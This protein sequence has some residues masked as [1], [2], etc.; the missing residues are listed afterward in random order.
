MTTLQSLREQMNLL[1]RQGKVAHAAAIAEQFVSQN[2]SNVDGL[3]TAAMMASQLAAFDRSAEL[4]R[5]VVQLQPRHVANRAALGKALL[6]SGH[7]DEAEAAFDKALALERTNEH[8]ICGKA[9]VFNR[10]GRNED[11]IALL[12]PLIGTAAETPEVALQY[13]TVCHQ[14]GRREEAMTV[15]RRHLGNSVAAGQVRARL[16]FLLGRVAEESQLYEEAFKAYEEANRIRAAQTRFD[17]PLYEQ[18]AESIMAF[19]SKERLATLRRASCHSEAPVF[20]CGMPRSGTTLLDQIVHA[21]PEGLGAGEHPELDK[22]FVALFKARPNLPFPEF[23]VDLQRS[24]LDA[25][26]WGYLA[27]VMKPRPKAARVSDKYMR[28]PHLMGFAWMLFPH[29]RIIWSR[30][31]PMDTCFSCFTNPLPPT[32]HPY[33]SDLT[34]LAF[35]YRIHE[36]L[37]KHWQ[38]VLDLPFLEVE[39]EKLVA[40]PEPMIRALIEFLG[41]PWSDACAR[42]YEA[43]RTVMTI[44]YDQVRRPVFDTS[45]GRWKHF[46]ASLEPLRLALEQTT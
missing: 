13:A 19:F 25:A 21:H 20:I 9:Q 10:R 16:A 6:L 11:A 36:R 43:D 29:A 27:T 15:V 1:V 40:S 12:S 37:M 46:A 3:L 22:R 41:L 32:I 33:A 23:L 44:S 26:A 38:S 18:R 34:Q 42:F 45:V 8:A 4:M 24:V 7:L 17:A 28:N 39:Y 31:D 14:T 5:R 35:V 2:P 30:R